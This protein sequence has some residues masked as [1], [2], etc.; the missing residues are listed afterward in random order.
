QSFEPPKK[1]E[2]HPTVA[3]PTAETTKASAPTQLLK[4]PLPPQ[5]QPPTPRFNLAPR[6]PRSLVLVGGALMVVVGGI[7]IFSLPHS[8]PN[9]ST[10]LES[11]AA[12]SVLS[13]KDLFKRAFDKKD[14]G[15]NQGAIADYTQAIQVN[16]DWGADNPNGSYYGLTSAYLSRGNA[17]SALGYKQ[18]A[19]A[20]YNQAIQLKPDYADAY[21]NRGNAYSALGDNQ[22]AITDYQKAADLYQQQG[23][24]QDQQ[25][26][27]NQIKKL[28]P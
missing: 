5:S 4:T 26:A 16:Q 23:K 24:T 20:D 12:S 27:L 3:A 8:Q 19:I 21:Y 6:N 14:K 1:I 2:S 7:F 11:T 28:K 17:Y 22:K 9:P 10:P 13:S 15:D 18:K 25:D